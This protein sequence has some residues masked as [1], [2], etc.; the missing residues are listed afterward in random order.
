MA[1]VDK[2]KKEAH[3]KKLGI[4]LKEIPDDAIPFGDGKHLWSPSEKALYDAQ[5]CR[6]LFIIDEEAP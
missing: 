5:A 6:D 4:K 3:D 1:K 2:P